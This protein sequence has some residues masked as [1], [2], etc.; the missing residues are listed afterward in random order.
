VEALKIVAEN[1]QALVEGAGWDV[2]NLANQSRTIP[3]L[4]HKWKQQSVSADI[5]R[6]LFLVSLLHEAPERSGSEN[7]ESSNWLGGFAFYRVS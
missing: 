4:R 5:S 3:R 2:E 6:T 7:G 1:F